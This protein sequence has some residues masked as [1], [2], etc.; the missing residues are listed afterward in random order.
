MESSI[1]HGHVVL[2]GAQWQTL[3]FGRAARMGATS[4]IAGGEGDGAR[5][6]VLL[7]YGGRDERSCG[8]TIEIGGV[9]HIPDWLA[10]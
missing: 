8:V 3:P 7:L 5:A 9:R 10:N 2:S 4:G 6:V 1:H